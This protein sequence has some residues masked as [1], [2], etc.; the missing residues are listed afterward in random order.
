VVGEVVLLGPSSPFLHFFVLPNITLGDN[1]QEV[2]WGWSSAVVGDKS[3]Y[4]TTAGVIFPITE[5]IWNKTKLAR[6]N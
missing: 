6:F 2:S 4:L 1:K 3:K 5:L